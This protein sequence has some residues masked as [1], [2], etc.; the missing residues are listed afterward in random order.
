M[1]IKLSSK[2]G[3][4][5]FAVSAMILLTVSNCKEGGTSGHS[6]E[7]EAGKPSQP[8]PAAPGF[9][10]VRKELVQIH[11]GRGSVCTDCRD[12]EG[13]PDIILKVRLNGKL[14]ARGSEVRDNPNPSWDVVSSPFDLAA[15][16][17]IVFEALESDDSTYD[18]EEMTEVLGIGSMNVSELA[19]GGEGLVELGGCLPEYHST[20]EMLRGELHPCMRLSFGVS[21]TSE[22]VG[23]RGEPTI[24]RETIPND[25][26]G[27]QCDCWLFNALE[28]FRDV[29]ILRITSDDK[30]PKVTAN[31]HMV[32]RY[33]GAVVDAMVDL[34]YIR[35]P[36]G[37]VVDKMDC[38]CARVRRGK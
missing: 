17:T 22:I 20:E 33:T 35:S 28:E 24:T 23:T 34:Q 9:E 7:K 18:S 38:T 15:G 32:D 25:V 30:G 19:K 36:D 1:A 27:L 37:W 4:G 31:L 6:P 12:V 5:L 10:V 16:G 29:R 3:W 26:L 2:P 14:I 13:L 11:V 8:V 21:W